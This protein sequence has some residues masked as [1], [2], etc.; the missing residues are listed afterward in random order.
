MQG[1]QGLP[2]GGLDG[3][4]RQSGLEKL[5]INTTWNRIWESKKIFFDK[6][7]NNQ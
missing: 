3:E 6:N 2:L 7:N 4:F 5:F 1:M